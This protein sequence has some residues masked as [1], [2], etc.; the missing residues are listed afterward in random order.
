VVLLLSVA[1][2]GWAWSSDRDQRR[3]ATAEQAALKAARQHVADVLSYDAPTVEK[4]MGRAEA[5][6][7]GDFADDFTK[8]ADDLI[9]PTAR[10]KGIRT[11]AEVTSAGVVR[12]SVD[13]VVVLLFVNQTTTS[14]RVPEPTLDGSRLE[15]TLQRAGD[16]WLIS[17]LTP[18]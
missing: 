13:E 8:M 12:S 3:T 16:G 9:I 11:H 10:A 7:T 6:L 5:H 17:E 2:G 14:S 18:L 15:V 1:A 4:D